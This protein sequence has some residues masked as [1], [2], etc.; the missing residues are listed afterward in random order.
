MQNVILMYSREYF[1]PF[2]KL[3][4]DILDVSGIIWIDD[5]TKHYEVD[6]TSYVTTNI[7]EM[8]KFIE[9]SG[10]ECVRIIS[11]DIYLIPV[12]ACL[13]LIKEKFED[14][15]RPYEF[16]FIQHG[17]FSDLSV[18][19]RSGYKIDWMLR[20]VYSLVTFIKTVPLF[21]IPKVVK[22]CFRSFYLS[23]YQC[24]NELAEFIPVFRHGVFWN[25]ADIALL[26]ENI[27]SKFE[28]ILETRSPDDERVSFQFSKNAPPIYISQPLYEDDLVDKAVFVTFVNRIK[29]EYPLLSVVIHPRSNRNIF[30]KFANNELIS[31][32]KSDNIIKT[33]LVLGHFSSLLLVVPKNVPMQTF[34][35]DNKVVKNSIKKF[36]S[37]YAIE[38]SN[39]LSCAFSDLSTL[40]TD[41]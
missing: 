35:L 20:S 19:K 41:D 18:A 4:C 39:M 9:Q 26:G 21:K 17:T 34:D 16:C 24:R 5:H 2:V 14:A 15:K 8:Q 22:I 25:R 3:T 28:K 32:D 13:R 29:N 11:F 23:S 1:S 12:V 33:S 27:I 10:N 30:T 6:G 37:S 40:L 36:Y 38:D 7:S 31:L